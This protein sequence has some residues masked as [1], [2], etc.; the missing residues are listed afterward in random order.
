MLCFDHW[1]ICKIFLKN[2]NMKLHSLGWLWWSEDQ[3]LLALL[4]ECQ[5]FLLQFFLHYS[6]FNCPSH[7]HHHHHHQSCSFQHW[8]RWGL[9]RSN[10]WWRE[11]TNEQTLTLIL[12]FI[13]P[14]L[15]LVILTIYCLNFVILTIYCLSFDSGL[16]LFGSSGSMSSGAKVSACSVHP[17]MLEW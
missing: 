11:V 4:L 2:E 5:L 1:L 8:L 6:H 7:H 15:I 10:T 12:S 16:T 13:F 9:K 3:L 17:F 14:N